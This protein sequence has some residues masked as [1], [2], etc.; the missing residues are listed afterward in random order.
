MQGVRARDGVT[1]LND[2]RCDLQRILANCKLNGI[3]SSP[4]SF[5]SYPFLGTATRRTILVHTASPMLGAV[6]NW[7]PPS[8]SASSPE[9]P[10]DVRSRWPWPAAPPSI[11][12]KL[13]IRID[14]AHH[15]VVELLKLLSRSQSQA[16][17]SPEKLPRLVLLLLKVLHFLCTRLPTL[18]TSPQVAWPQ[19]HELLAL[20]GFVF[21]CGLDVE[22]QGI[23]NHGLRFHVSRGGSWSSS[24]E[25]SC[26]SQGA[27]RCKDTAV[28]LRRST[29]RGPAFTCGGTST[30]DQWILH[31]CGLEVW[32][33]PI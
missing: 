18:E 28:R 12:Q 6:G 8:P 5:F 9:L 27:L 32:A 13:L 24:T 1:Y 3:L 33:T 16:A 21:A 14:V 15:L 10:I 30:S 11:L 2:R 20:L 19:V 23:V 29:G 25:P 17:L 7:S 26:E 4:T 31:H 22:V